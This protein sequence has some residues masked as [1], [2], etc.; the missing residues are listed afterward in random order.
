MLLSYLF[1]ALIIIE[2]LN[3][4]ILRTS[5]KFSRIFCFLI[6]KTY[7]LPWKISKGA[8]IVQKLAPRSEL[9]N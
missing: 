9:A 8:S 5:R 1:R 2:I 4:K 6:L 7:L 3:K